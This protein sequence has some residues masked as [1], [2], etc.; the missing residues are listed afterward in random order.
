MLHEKHGDYYYLINEPQDIIDFAIKLLTER[1]ESGTYYK[2]DP[3]PES[4]DAFFRS[5]H[6]MSHA[7]AIELVEKHGDNIRIGN[8]IVSHEIDSMQRAYKYKLAEI[9]EYGQIEK[10]V[11]EKDGK[12][13]WSILSERSGEG[14]QYET[15]STESIE[16]HKD[17][18]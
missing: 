16:N 7:D 11:K 5:V 14:A 10:A 3:A 12:L 1:F 18:I 8:R 17:N 6:N 2:P 15:F 4:F 9:Q 13:A